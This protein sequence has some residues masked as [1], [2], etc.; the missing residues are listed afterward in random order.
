MLEQVKAF[1]IHWYGPENPTQ[2][3][4]ITLTVLFFL[5]FPRSSRR[6]AGYM[7]LVVIGCW[8]VTAFV[9]SAYREYTPQ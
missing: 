1:L 9:S 8:I 4:I 5:W 2:K 3:W 6:F 7:F